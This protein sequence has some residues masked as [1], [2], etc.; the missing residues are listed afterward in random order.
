MRFDKSSEISSFTRTSE[1]YLSI[2]AP[3]AKVGVYKYRTSSGGVRRELVPATTLFNQDSINTLKLKPVT[4]NHPNELVSRK[5]FK[6]FSVGTVGETIVNNDGLLYA[7][8]I[9]SSEEAI[10]SVEAGLNQLSPAYTC[11]LLEKSGITEDGEEYDCIQVNRSY[12]HLAL[13]DKARGGDELAIKMDACDSV[14]IEL[15]ETNN[16]GT[17][18]PTVRIDGVDH[19]IENPA[20]VGH[21]AELNVKAERADAL[22]AEL[23]TAKDSVIALTAKC[24]SLESALAER[25]DSGDED[26]VAKRVNSRIELIKKAESVLGSVKMDDS[27]MVIMEAVITKLSPEAK[28]DGFDGREREIYVSAR[29]DSCIEML[30]TNNSR[31]NRSDSTRGTNENTEKKDP[32]QARKDSLEQKWNGAK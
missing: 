25:K 28:F 7:N 10:A 20:I 30:A 29:F 1:G 26:E 17:S 9:V 12:N 27:D 14:E 18:M 13:V 15:T 16:K 2:S 4:R 5:T 22:E 31:Q 3:I 21:I 19:A 6:K 23:T 8:F 11:E 24:D 32:V